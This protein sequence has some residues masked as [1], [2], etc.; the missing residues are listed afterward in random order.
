MKIGS[1]WHTHD[2]SAGVDTLACGFVFEERH[3]S[4]L[5][6]TMAAGAFFVKDWRDIPGKS[7]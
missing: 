1:S 6:G 3:R 7:R 4:K 2:K 5:A